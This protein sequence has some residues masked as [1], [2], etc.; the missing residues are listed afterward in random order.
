MSVM[1]K[2]PLISRLVERMNELTKVPYCIP[3]LPRE[4]TILVVWEAI[5]LF[6]FH[7]LAFRAVGISSGVHCAPRTVHPC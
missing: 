4:I 1:T 3:L 7:R 2:L 5:L 6:C